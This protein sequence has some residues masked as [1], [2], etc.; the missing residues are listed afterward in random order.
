MD[1]DVAMTM[2]VW[3]ELSN[4]GFVK[5]ERDMEDSNVNKGWSGLKE[6]LGLGNGIGIGEGIRL[7]LGIGEGIR[8]GIGEDIRLGIG[9]GLGNGLGLEEADDGE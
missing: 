8:L 9:N 7:G 5:P 2:A 6:G 1:F 4:S 3:A